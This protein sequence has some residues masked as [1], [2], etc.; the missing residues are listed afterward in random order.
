MVVVFLHIYCT[1]WLLRYDVC[2]C[3]CMCVRAYMCV[4]GMGRGSEKKIVNLTTLQEI[5]RN[6]KFTG[7]PSYHSVRPLINR[8]DCLLFSA[9]L[10]NGS[11]PREILNARRST[12]TN[13][14]PHTDLWP[15]S[16]TSSPIQKLSPAPQNAI[17]APRIGI[18]IG[19]SP[20][21]VANASRRRLCTL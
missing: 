20:P 18:T 17:T 8:L 9:A 5:Y 2:V 4:G 3:V 19:G 6:L 7:N 21:V 12:E 13:V 14:P 15:P 10:M 1:Y 11:G 16:P